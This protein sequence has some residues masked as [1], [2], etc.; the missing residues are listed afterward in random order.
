M[1]EA[2]GKLDGTVKFFL[3]GQ[4]T[5]KVLQR[6]ESDVSNQKTNG[7]GKSDEFGCKWAALSA[8]IQFQ[9]SA[10]ARGANAVVDLVS[11]YK[12]KESRNDATM[13]CH[14]GSFVIGVALKGDYA[15]LRD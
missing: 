13:E 8:L 9:E 3:A 5:P 6:L 1:P 12:K 14:A 2:Q 15:K 7:V 10:K 11:Y 4:K